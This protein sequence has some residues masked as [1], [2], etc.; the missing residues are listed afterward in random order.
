MYASDQG[1]VGNIFISAPQD[2]MNT[3]GIDPD[4]SS[5]IW[6]H[7]STVF[8]GDDCI[9]VKSGLN[10]A[11]RKFNRP[12][13]NVTIERLTCGLG[14]GLSIGSE[15][16]GGIENITFREIK[17]INTNSGC[18]LKT[19]QIRGGYIRNV[20]YHKISLHE[21]RY[22]TRINSD[23]DHGGPID[24]PTISNVT[25]SQISGTG[26]IAG[27]LSCLSQSPC[28]N[29]TFSQVHLDANEGGFS[30]QN[31]FGEAT[32]VKPQLCI[33]HKN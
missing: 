28:T 27:T 7:D 32:D 6:I 16:S 23:Y 33:Q 21:V 13:V 15:M 12:C 8:N 18:Y 24:L 30:C 25:F 26:K 31:I 10:E 20:L 19:S 22:M 4:N 3:D 2:A 11:G 17:M 9:A 29:M 14:Q 1:E 5:N